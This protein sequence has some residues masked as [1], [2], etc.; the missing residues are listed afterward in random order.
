M[1]FL[2]IDTAN[3]I[4]TCSR[5]RRMQRHT[6]S[7][8]GFRSF[9]KALSSFEKMLGEATKEEYW[10]P[11][12]RWLRR[13]R[14]HMS[15]APLPFTWQDPSIPDLE[16]LMSRHIAQCNLIYPKFAQQAHNL[17]T[18]FSQVAKLSDNPLL[19]RLAQ[20]WQFLPDGSA[21][22]LV[23]ETRLVSATEIALRVN[24]KIGSSRIDVIAPAQI[25]S[26][27]CYQNLFVFGP[28]RWFP[29]HIFTA[30]RA[31]NVHII[32]Y[33][34]IVDTWHQ[35]PAFV[36][37]SRTNSNFGKDGS[38]AS[39]IILDEPMENGVDSDGLLLPEDIVPVIDWQALSKRF[40]QRS[41]D[42]D[43]YQE[44]VEARLLVLAGDLVVFVEAVN[45]A[46]VL[47]IS[48][49][50]EEGDSVPDRVQRIPLN[51][52]KPGMFVLLRT[53]GGGDYIVPVA[54]RLMGPEVAQTARRSQERWK[55]PLRTRVLKQGLFETCIHLL[56]N[57]SQ[58]ANEINVR[59]WMASRT[60]RPGDQQDFLAILR[61][62]GLEAN[63]G[64]FWKYTEIIHNAHRRAGFH[65]REQLLR[66]VLLS[67]LSQL[68]KFG[69]MEFVLPEADGGSLTA[70]RIE[71]IA[72]ETISIPTSY[73]GELF[74]MEDIR[75]QR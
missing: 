25:D 59:N 11:F 61:V 19:D 52:L 73:I 56:E 75:W 65:I 8:T 47:A 39:N 57:G 42:P 50:A 30:P 48:L 53:E 4:Y 54:D 27:Q 64:E 74:P 69:K 10:T 68:R 60:I 41:S 63:F 6:V 22:I 51:E 31:K 21:A 9:C 71:Q 67:E 2:T 24:Q 15:A 43:L 29:E 1:G 16:R 28:A 70:F 55:A 66:Q 14:F 40:S 72:P 13:Y 7:H 58:R 18:L 38:F 17:L 32:S 45:N 34:W 23:K 46:K 20:E 26:T 44:E 62:L 3:E 36:G 5:D 37:S 12:L 49:Y 33:R 35:E